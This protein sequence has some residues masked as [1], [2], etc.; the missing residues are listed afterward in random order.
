MKRVLGNSVFPAILCCFIAGFAIEIQAQDGHLSITGLRE[1]TMLLVQCNDSLGRACGYGSG[2]LMWDY[3]EDGSAEGHAYLLTA[4]HVLRGPHSIDLLVSGEQ[5]SISYFT[6]SPIPLFDSVGRRLE[7]TYTN[8][9]GHTSD[10]ALLRVESHNFARKG[11]IRIVARS[12]CAFSDS[13]YVG[14]RLIA[15]G[16]ADTSIFDFV[17]C[18][19]PLATSG[20]VSF[21]TNMSYVMD[22]IAHEGMSGGIVFKEYPGLGKFGYKAV[23]IVSAPV[24][25]YPEYTWITKIDYID[26]IFISLTD[27]KWG[28]E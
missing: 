7:L 12:Q 10:L 2:C 22:K 16:F 24:S 21:E 11:V 26:S 27:T 15:F 19:K 28:L 23:G 8:E 25:R 13:V 5:D 18:G 3:S 4:T 20:V 1:R 14:D 17:A 9:S 6:K